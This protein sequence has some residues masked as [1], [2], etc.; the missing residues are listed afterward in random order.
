MRSL[1]VLAVSVGLMASGANVFAG[2][3]SCG[4]AAAKAEAKAEVEAKAPAGQELY[5]VVDGMTCGGCTGKVKANLSK[6]DGVDVKK[7]CHKSGCAQVSY[8]PAKVKPEQVTQAIK[9][10]GFKVK[11]QQVLYHVK[12]MTCGGCSGKVAKAIEAVD[13]VQ[14]QEVSHKDGH[15][16][17]VF[18]PAKVSEKDIKTAINA[19]GFKVVKGH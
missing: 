16:T 17:V 9:S 14:S 19:T 13:G 6:I 12:G 18:D 3:G 15:A 5:Y 1:F 8:D 4:P 10:A 7:V 11:G 2:C